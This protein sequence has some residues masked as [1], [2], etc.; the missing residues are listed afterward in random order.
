MAPL[1]IRQEQIEAFEGHAWRELRRELVNAFRASFPERYEELG[2]EASHDN[3]LQAMHRAGSHGFTTREAFSRF[4]E[5]TFHL[6]QDFDKAPQLD[7][8]SGILNAPNQ[9]P[10]TMVGRLYFKALQLGLI[11][12]PEVRGASNG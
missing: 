8:V 1:R 4:V 11:C 5:L 7:W 10:D 2:E 3:V 12:E 9:D 6:G